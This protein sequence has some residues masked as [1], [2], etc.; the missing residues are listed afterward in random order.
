MKISDLTQQIEE[1]LKTL[2]TPS[3]TYLR[4]S[5]S[6]MRII[7]LLYSKFMYNKSLKNFKKDYTSEQVIEATKLSLKFLMKID[8][9]KLDDKHIANTVI[10]AIG[11]QLEWNFFN[12]DI[13]DDV[14]NM[15]G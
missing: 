14:L 13:L 15:D 8:F 5:Y 7:G 9:T 3:K 1:I 12:E 4:N 11:K 2:D 6:Q 10:N